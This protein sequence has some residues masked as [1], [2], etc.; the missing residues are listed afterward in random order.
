MWARS[1]VLVIDDEEQTCM[2]LKD[3]LGHENCDVA[4]ALNG[5]QGLAMAERLRPDLILLDVIM[6]DLDGFE[7]CRQVRANEE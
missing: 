6:P 1:Q 7:V 4:I 5:T 3:L 2:V